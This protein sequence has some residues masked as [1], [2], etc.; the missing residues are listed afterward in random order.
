MQGVFFRATTQRIGRELS[1]TGW[2]RN[3]KDGSVEAFV[4]GE[5]SDIRALVERLKA[6]VSAAK[7]SR[8]Q[9]EWSEGGREFRTFEVRGDF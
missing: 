5:A 4:E 6:E 9:E 8:V 2:V 7:V 3:L 1:L